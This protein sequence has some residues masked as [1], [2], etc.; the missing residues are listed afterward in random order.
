VRYR[1]ENRRDLLA[2]LMELMEQSDW[3][4]QNVVDGIVRKNVSKIQRLQ[5]F[6][7]RISFYHLLFVFLVFSSSSSSESSRSFSTSVTRRKGK[8]ISSGLKITDRFSRS[9][10]SFFNFCKNVSDGFA[11]GGGFVLNLETN[12]TGGSALNLF[13]RYLSSIC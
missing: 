3:S 7:S 9:E 8:L 13:H 11:V 5:E 12:R 2:Q 1:F 4:V 6:I 10:L